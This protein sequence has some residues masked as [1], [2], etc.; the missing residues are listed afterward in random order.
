MND[1]A[2]VIRYPSWWTCTKG[3]G[4]ADTLANRVVFA[5]SRGTSTFQNISSRISMLT[6]HLSFLWATTLRNNTSCCWKDV[7]FKSPGSEFYISWFCFGKISW[8]MN[9]PA[10][11]NICK[12]HRCQLLC[13]AWESFNWP[14]PLWRYQRVRTTVQDKRY[15]NSNWCCSEDPQNWIYGTNWKKSESCS[16]IIMNEALD[17]Y[18]LQ[19]SYTRQICCP[20]P[21]KSETK[22]LFEIL[23]SNVLELG[24][25]EKTW[26]RYH[27]ISFQCFYAG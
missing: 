22:G 19:E 6:C 5:P 8:C 14:W 23:V 12:E 7:G 25:L 9:G 3:N 1:G 18:I 21:A 16:H 17:P 10:S 11:C 4:G 20:K 24:N 15:K 26:S 13:R 27:D 2:S